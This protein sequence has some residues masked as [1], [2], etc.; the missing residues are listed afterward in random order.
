ME[1]VVSEAPLGKLHDPHLTP[2]GARLDVLDRV[3]ATHDWLTV[4]RTEAQLLADLAQGYD[5]VILGADKWAQVVDPS[6][7]GGAAARDAAVARLPH[8]ALAPRPPHPL[9]AAGDGLT[10]LEIDT[11]HHEVSATAVRAGRRQW[12]APGAGST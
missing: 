12:L 3:T 6:W 2:I 9:P 4:V 11:A 1:L 8:I 5:V 7:Y 10:I